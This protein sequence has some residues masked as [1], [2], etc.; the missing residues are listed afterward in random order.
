M[1]LAKPLTFFL[2]KRSFNDSTRALQL[3]TIIRAVAMGNHDDEN[4]Y[5]SIAH[6][7]RQHSSCTHNTE[8]HSTGR[9]E[10]LHDGQCDTFMEI[11][12]LHSQRH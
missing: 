12:F 1:D 3:E 2:P 11:P 5:T 8:K 7:H 10:V 6:E 4:K 9:G